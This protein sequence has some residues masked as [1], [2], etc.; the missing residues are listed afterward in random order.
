M[1][2]CLLSLYGLR[3][4]IHHCFASL[5]IIMC[6]IAQI[7]ACMP[8]DAPWISCIASR[9]SLGLCLMSSLLKGEGMGTKL[10]E[11]LLIG[12]LREKI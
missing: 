2:T 10:V 5:G 3:V 6:L 11:L 9:S 1:A 7:L 4:Q 12:W 8:Y